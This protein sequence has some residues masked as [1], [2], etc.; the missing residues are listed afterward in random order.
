MRG[1]GQQRGRGDGR[2]FGRGDGFRRGGPGGSRG[3]GGRGRP[4]DFKRRGGPGGAKGGQKVIIEPHEAFKGLF[5]MRGKDG[6][7]LMTKNMVPGISVYN[8]KR[9]AVEVTFAANYRR[10]IIRWSIECGIHIDP[11]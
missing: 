6:D 7:M 2:R 9:V 8:E 5:I 3:P 10:V 11:S 4:G 1:R